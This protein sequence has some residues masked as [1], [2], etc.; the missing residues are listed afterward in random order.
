MA[1]MESRQY[2]NENVEHKPNNTASV[3]CQYTIAKSWNYLQKHS[4][5]H[6]CIHV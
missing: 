2:E 1:A 6:A 3:K 4:Q 5:L